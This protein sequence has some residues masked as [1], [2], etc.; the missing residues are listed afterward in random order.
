MVDR[1]SINDDDKGYDIESIWKPGTKKC[2]KFIEVKGRKWN[3]NSFIISDEELE[4]A[5]EKGNKYVIYF[6]KN[7]SN[8]SLGKKCYYFFFCTNC[9][10]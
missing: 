3:E 7:V 6:W 4:V 5:E 8:N 2:D 10:S 1:V 9:A